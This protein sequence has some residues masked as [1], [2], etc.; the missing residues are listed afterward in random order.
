MVPLNHTNLLGYI[1]REECKLK[2]FDIDKGSVIEEYNKNIPTVR[3]LGLE[4][5]RQDSTK[6]LPILE[7]IEMISLP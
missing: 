6:T 4:E 1:D 5:Y 2:V 3:A 7:E